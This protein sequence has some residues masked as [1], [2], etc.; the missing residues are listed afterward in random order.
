MTEITRIISILSLAFL[1]FFCFQTGVFLWSGHTLRQN[2]RRTLIFIEF[3]TGF[4]LLSDALAYFFRGN[5]SGAGYWMVRISNFCVFACNFS[6][7]FFFCF[8]VCEFIR[9]SRLSL[10]LLLHPASAVKSGIPVQLFIVLLL[11]LAGIAAV[12]VSQITD[13]FYY[14]DENNVY[15]RSAFSRSRCSC[16]TGGSLR[17][18]SSFPSCFT[19]SFP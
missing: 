9:Q 4:L 10:S 7:S 1:S 8:Y 14:F 2:G 11:C 3:F 6:V 15:H 12:T 19:L 17:R 18:M 13:L 5:G 16:R